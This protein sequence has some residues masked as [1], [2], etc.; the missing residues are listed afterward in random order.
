MREKIKKFIILC[1]IF[2]Q[3]IELNLRNESI[4]RSVLGGCTSIGVLLLFFFIFQSAAL[5]LFARTNFKVELG[6]G[7][8][9]ATR[10][11]WVRGRPSQGDYQLEEVHVRHQNRESGRRLTPSELESI[12][13]NEH[14]I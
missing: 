8:R 14:K 10:K 12:V 1:D 2:G 9:K 3:P 13:A 6:F 11:P 7:K 4:F 5:S